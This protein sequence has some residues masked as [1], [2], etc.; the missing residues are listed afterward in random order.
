MGIW[1][2]RTARQIARGAVPVRAARATGLCK[3]P[4]KPHKPPCFRANGAPPDEKTPELCG[5]SSTPFSITR[6]KHNKTPIKTRLTPIKWGSKWGFLGATI[7]KVKVLH[8]D[9]YVT[10]KSQGAG[11]HGINSHK[12]NYA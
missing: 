8:P 5:F 4:T 6:K 2:I 11:R 10:K 12:R 1:Y 9:V 7:N 3:T